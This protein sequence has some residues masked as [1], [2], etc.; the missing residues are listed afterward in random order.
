MPKHLKQICFGAAFA[1]LLSGC[2][3]GPGTIF[4]RF[5]LED[6]QS[7]STGAR[8]RVVTSHN[9]Q[10]GTRPGYVHPTQIVCT[11]PSPDVALAVA[12]S[13]GAGLS[14]LSQGAGSITSQQAEGIVQ[15][16]ERTISVQ[17]LRERMFRACEAYSNGAITGTT[18]TLLMNGIGREIVTI[19]LGETAGG[20]F[21]RSLAGAGV[22]GSASA[23]AQLVGLASGIQNIGDASQEL[24]AREL[25]LSEAEAALATAQ[26]ANTTNG[27]NDEDTDLEPLQTR[28]TE[29]RAER[30]AARTLL[31]GQV[32]ATAAASGQVSHLTTG[33][34]ISGS[35][36][37]E[38]ASTLAG[39][40]Q[41]FLDPPPLNRIV[42]ACM[43]EMATINVAPSTENSVQEK[44]FNLVINGNLDPQT[45]L[46]IN[47]IIAPDA[48]R[49]GL[50][51][52]CRT[53]LPGILDTA[54]STAR[55]THR[56]DSLIERISLETRDNEAR[57]NVITQYE[58]LVKRCDGLDESARPACISAADSALSGGSSALEEALAAH[59]DT[60][61]ITPSISSQLLPSVAYLAA[62]SMYTEL[63]G[64]IDDG[65]KNELFV[66]ELDEDSDADDTYQAVRERI[67]G[68]NN[69]VKA[70]LAEA[71]ILKGALDSSFGPPQRNAIELL[72][73]EALNLLRDYQASEAGVGRDILH[74][75][76]ADNA[77]SRRQENEQYERYKSQLGP[78][79]ARLRDLL[80]TEDELEKAREQVE[81]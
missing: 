9:P 60:P 46:R 16:A 66:D 43:V 12:N 38:V 41:S 59:A 17:L 20:H 4:N 61:P 19:S 23:D 62:E 71:V 22:G 30:D 13:F 65:N 34:A 14:I 50:Y 27:A 2:T 75:Q 31:S 26:A 55:E 52:F 11:E 36:S 18:Y 37:N 73:T 79:I 10:I 57:A 70:A 54:D 8:Q 6:G 40:Q 67:S 45:A 53:Y 25:E 21:G 64:I 68:H 35:P 32:S 47:S 48:R 24:A 69:S 77:D 51:E 33:G 39:M 7:V 72:E 5:S 15:L 49:S 56:I 29:A 78:M 58:T 1:V 80:E 3:Q 63:S 74:D 44:L 42:D 28:V 76:I 81:S